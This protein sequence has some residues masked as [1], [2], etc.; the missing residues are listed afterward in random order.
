MSGTLYIVATPIGNLSDFTFR[1]VEILSS[2][3]IIAAEDTRRTIKLL[4]HYKIK[5]SMMPFHQ[6]NR[7]VIGKKILRMLETKD[8]A[9]V[10]D[11][12]TPCISDPGFEL[13]AEAREAGFSVECIPGACAAIAAMVLTGFDS[14]RFVFE[15]F[16]PTDNKN[17]RKRLEILSRENRAII[18]YESPHR[19]KKTLERLGDV[20]LGRTM[21]LASEI[22]KIYE[23][24]KITKAEDA[25]DI[26][27]EDSPRGEYVIVIDA[28]KDEDVE[29]WSELDISQHVQMY[30]DGGSIKMEAIKLV[31]KDRN[32]PKSEIYKHVVK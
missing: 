32:M 27:S 13:V 24:V 11:A 9:L 1:G 14:S 5:T 10:S 16:L 25:K 6:H 19:L 29:D 22:T 20:F 8:V 7:H 23:S 4:N 21:A 26:F 2:V 17:L 30:I 28:N 12:G 18:I 3:D 15:G 31:A